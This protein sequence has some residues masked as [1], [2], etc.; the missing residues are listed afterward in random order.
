MNSF[1]YN[2]NKIVGYIDIMPNSNAN[3]DVVGYCDF[4]SEFHK[5]SEEETLELFP[6]KGRVFAHNFANRHYD[7]RGMLACLSVKPNEKEGE[8]LDNFIGSS[9]I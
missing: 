4:Q 2:N 8:Y 9:A 1:D 5:L 6:P 7:F 3:I